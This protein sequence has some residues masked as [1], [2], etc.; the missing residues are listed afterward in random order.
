MNDEE[1]T[2]L[3]EQL[4]GARAELE[5]LQTTVA[6][7]EARATHVEE[8]LAEAR[9]ELATALETIQARDSELG[10]LRERAGAL[11]LSVLNSA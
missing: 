1:I 9:A 5:E 7:R 8:Q 10:G 4:A 6:D 2:E 11:E 3:Q